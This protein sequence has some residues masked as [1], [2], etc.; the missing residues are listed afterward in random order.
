MQC[1]SDCCK[2]FVSVNSTSQNGQQSS[3]TSTLVSFMETLSSF[4][5]L[6]F[7]F[8]VAKGSRDK[9]SA[10]FFMTRYVLHLNIP[11][12]KIQGPS[13]QFDSLGP[14]YKKLLKGLSITLQEYLC[15][16][17]VMSPLFNFIVD[18]IPLLDHSTLFELGIRELHGKVGNWHFLG[19]SI[20]SIFLCENGCCRLI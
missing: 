15:I 7:L 19:F 1:L 9:Q 16:L 8:L 4:R 3:P 6:L 11:A 13:V 14:T 18:C 20:L 12:L 17:K 5:G 10:G 2:A